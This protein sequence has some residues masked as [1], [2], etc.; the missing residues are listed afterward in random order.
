MSEEL[1]KWRQQ[2]LDSVSPSFCAAKWLNS[3]IHLGHGYTHSCHLPIPHPIDKEEIKKN[4]SALHN[5]KHKKIQREKMLKGERPTE[6]EYCWKIEDIGRK[7][8]SDRVYKSQIYDNS[9]IENISKLDPYENVIPKT[10]EISFDRICNLAC[11]YCNSGYSTTWSN[12]IK[13]NGPYQRMK[14]DGAGAYRHT[15]DWAEPYRKFNEGNPYVKAFFEWWPELSK[16]LKEIRVTGGEPTMSHQFWKFCDLV[17]SSELPNLRM[18]VNSNLCIKEDLMKDLI[19][20]TKHANIKE[21]DLYTSCEAVGIQAEYIRDGLDYNQWITNLERFIIEADFR[22]VTIMMTITS[23]SLFSITEFLEDM[24]ELKKKYGNHRPHVDLNILR[25]PSFM[26]PLAFPPHIRTYCKKNLEDW[27]EKNKNSD[28]LVD[29]ERAQIQRLIDYLDVVKTSHKR[30]DT[31]IQKL[32][33]DFK[34]FY[35]QYDERRNKNFSQVFPQIVVDW[36]NEIEIDQT[37]PKSDLGT[38]EMVNYDV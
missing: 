17:K 31:E 20:F 33:N 8:I 1:F 18:A 2:T 13:K 34:S 9:E 36:Y 3:T 12:D 23:L 30:A 22:A 16:E 37:I 19:D 7:N 14:S 28:F 21:F 27:F 6:C 5:T 25:W 11:S 29:G 38:G 35:S 24:I 4:P 32:H 10:L 15:G 26:S